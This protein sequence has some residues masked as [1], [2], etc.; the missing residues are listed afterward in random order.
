MKRFQFK[1]ESLLKYKH[2]L[3]Q[4]ARQEMAKAVSQV[5]ACEHR[6]Q[7]LLEERVTAADQLDSMVEEG[8]NARQF[9]L[10]RDFIVSV[11]RTI[12]DERARKVK[13]EKVLD[14]KR[15]ILKKRTIDKKALE[16]LRVRRE[17][18]YTREMIREEQKELD[19]ISS[20]KTARE[21]SNGQI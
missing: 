21:I 19:E 6:I 11:E 16:R 18:E 4:M 5:N 15:E 2:H 14:E 13:L 1:L 20:M 12:R 17:E 3:E 8:V 7:T 9:N 10:H